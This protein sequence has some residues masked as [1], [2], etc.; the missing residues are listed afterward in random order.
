MTCLMRK[1]QIRAGCGSLSFSVWPKRV[2][3]MSSFRKLDANKTKWHISLRHT[4]SCL[5][6]AAEM[7]HRFREKQPNT[8]EERFQPPPYLV[9]SNRTAWWRVSGLKTQTAA[10]SRAA[11]ATGAV[12]QLCWKQTSWS[13][14]R[15]NPLSIQA[16]EKLKSHKPECCSQS[17]TRFQSEPFI[18][19]LRMDFFLA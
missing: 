15:S 2:S 16:S 12:Q 18:Q 8:S 3:I 17:A 1:G 10:N 9:E 14:I 6:L 5:H 19:F 4:G 11:E 13:K 7:S